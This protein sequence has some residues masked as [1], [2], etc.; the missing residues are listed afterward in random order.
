MKL[1]KKRLSLSKESV[2]VL[3]S[4]EMLQVLGGT[5]TDTSEGTYRECTL[6]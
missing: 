2:R 4:V 1:K 3:K 5:D 6:P